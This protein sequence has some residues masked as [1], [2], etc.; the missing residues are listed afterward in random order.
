MREHLL[1]A[2]VAFL[3]ERADK[4]DICELHEQVTDSESSVGLRSRV[5]G[6]R[7]PRGADAQTPIVPI[8][9]S[10]APGSSS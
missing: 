6:C 3:A 1:R 9:P 7:I 8:S 4:W 10:R 2:L 5:P